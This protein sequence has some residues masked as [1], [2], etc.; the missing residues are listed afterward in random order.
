MNPEKCQIWTRWFAGCMF[1]IEKNSWTKDKGNLDPPSILVISPS[2]PWN[3]LGDGSFYERRA[4]RHFYQGMVR[5]Y[6]GTP[7]QASCFSSIYFIFS[8]V[9]NPTNK[10][11][12]LTI[13]AHFICSDQTSNSLVFV[14]QCHPWIG[15]ADTHSTWRI[16]NRVAITHLLH[17]ISQ[18]RT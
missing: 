12:W 11:L 4:W 14:H 6:H 9:E 5:S 18:K 17:R 2:K 10:H 8:I 16:Y 7:C 3:F 15:N 13:A 1:I